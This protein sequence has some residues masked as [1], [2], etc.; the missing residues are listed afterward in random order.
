MS[1]HELLPESELRE[2]FRPRRPE[3]EAFR[4]G[5]ER[6]IAERREREAA[7]RKDGEREDDAA[8]LRSVFL[9]RV[10]AWLPADPLTGAAAGSA[11]GKWVGVKLLPAA[12]AFPALV[13]G[14]AV[15]GFVASLRSL[16][17]SA[18]GA[19]AQAA[20]GHRPA[21]SRG[22]W[23]LNLISM[24]AP[25][26]F[27]SASLLAAS[28]TVDLLVGVL[29]LAMLGLALSA[30]SLS[31]ASMLS[32]STIVDLCSGL[33]GVLSGSV[34]L[35]AAIHANAFLIGMG[36]GS[37]LLVLLLGFSCCRLLAPKGADSS[38]WWLAGAPLVL[39]T[40]LVFLLTNPLG[41]TRTSPES[42]REQL[43]GLE[44]D[45]LELKAWQQAGAL[46]RAMSAAGMELPDLSPVAREVE[47]ALEHEPPPVRAPGTDA[48]REPSVH[49]EVWS[50]AADMGLV[51]PEQWRRLAQRRLEAYALDR[52]IAAQPPAAAHLEPWQRYL[53]PMLLAS[54]TPT[55]EQRANAVHNVESNW[56][57]AGSLNAVQ[58][59][60]MVVRMLDALGE[61]ARVDALRPRVHELLR[62][63]WIPPGGASLYGKEG[64]F[65]SEPTQF[66][67]SFADSTFDA[68]ELMVRL[69]VPEGIELTVLHK[70]LVQGS[71]ADAT[72]RDRADYLKAHERAAPVLLQGCIGI[73]ERTQLERFLDARLLMATL[74]IV[75]LCLAAILLVPREGAP[76]PGARP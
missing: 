70:H 12:L 47:R 73:P 49:P 45:C 34:F 3:P 67:T 32:R 7:A 56:P 19:V 13:L 9:R 26:V 22:H 51:S 6:R 36:V 37:S 63:H 58:R 46:Y 60:W 62:R 66:R 61:T 50:T 1:E 29:L 68:V 41:L 53:V 75:A 55:P 16:R 64:G 2:L 20:P 14:T 72:F 27:L 74:L 65:T 59:A 17:R 44:L 40:P 31:R 23:I 28:W 4:A 24:L 69:G 15:G 35:W 71:R 8:P 38:R 76:G 57:E 10:A 48:R 33:L 18:R 42:L 21:G 11:A 39:V 43:A 52:L 25:M 5:V 54:R 30:R